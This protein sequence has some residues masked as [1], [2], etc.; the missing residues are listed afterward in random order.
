MGENDIDSTNSELS[1]KLLFYPKR[2]VVSII[3]KHILILATT[4]D[5]VWKFEQENVRILQQMGYVVHYAANLREPEYISNETELQKMGV[6]IHHIEIARS[7]FILQDNWQALQE[8]LNLMKQY[9]IQAIHCH[10]PVGGVLGRLAGR[11]SHYRRIHIIYTAHGF[12]FYRGAPLTNRLLYYQAERFLARYTDVL[13][14]INSEDYESALKLPI[15][16]GGRIYRIPG[17][18]LDLE[19]FRPPTQEERQ[20]WRKQLNI[21]TDTF[22][23]VSAGELNENKNHRIVLEALKK[24]RER[25]DG[26]INIRYGICGDGFFRQRLEEW[27]KNM[28]LEDVVTLY[29]YCTNMPEILG[30]ADAAVFPSKR[31][32]LGMAGLEALAMGI[33]VIASDNRGTREYMRHGKNGYLCRHDDSESFLKGIEMIRRR[34]PKQREEMSVCLRASAEPFSRANT[35]RIMREI[36]ASIDQPAEEMK[37]W[38]K[39]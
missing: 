3:E 34:N 7:P 11:L 4:K 1:S 31:E 9:P 37:L 14:V 24:L 6:L 23:L 25:S 32:G 10:T 33:P 20:Y 29:G 35:R 19:R 28:K 39:K 5:F 27:I 8:L 26:Q 38:K 2:R 21:D 36:Y 15:K 12:H 18:G 16:K 13:I 22:F 17:A 30:G